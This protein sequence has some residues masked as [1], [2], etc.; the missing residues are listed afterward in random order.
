[1]WVIVSGCSGAGKSTLLEALAA[2][3][4]T[5]VR[6]PGRRLIAA[7]RASEGRE[8]ALPWVDLPKF[9]QAAIVMAQADLAAAPTDRR[10]FFDR[11]LIDAACG[12]DALT[13][14][15]TAPALADA[16]PFHRRLFLAPPWPEIYR[17]DADRPH[18]LAAATAE[19]ER[20]RACYT[21][22]GFEIV[23]LPKRP[24]AERVAF[25]LATLAGREVQ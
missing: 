12:W 7:H 24:V 14:A 5:V 2:R 21:R 11:G 25:V 6:E 15:D 17:T 13:G 4:E 16:Y 19:Y 23:L 20:L 8:G 3:G 18:D 9:L 10:V 1:M 22:L